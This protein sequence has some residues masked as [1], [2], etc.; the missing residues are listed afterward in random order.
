MPLPARD[1]DP[2]E[3]GVPCQILKALGHHLIIA[4]PEGKPVSA[5]PIMVT[6]KGLGPLRA[7]LRA[8]AQGRAAYHALT[9][10]AE[11]QAPITY[12]AINPA[13][14]DALLLPGGHA[15]GMRPYL[16]SPLL[17]AVVVSFF[18]ADKPVAAICH[19]TL[20][21]ARSVAAN[22]KSVLHG[23]KTTGLTRAQEL[24]AWGMTRAW[25]KDYY[26]TYPTPLETEI[27]TLLASPAD[28]IPGPAAI[29]RDRPD[30]LERGFTVLDGKY[31]SARW[32]GD[33]HRFANEFAALLQQEV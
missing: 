16:E 7:V 27:R 4:T 29:K 8:N 17:Q 31:L 1:F 12:A 26:R 24:L 20:L 19:G 5:D 22:G 33:A 23:R 13:E 28:F 21:A 25:M 32:P 11:F 10:S 9:R 30:R 14:Y 3:T 18:A 2:T 6:G 15:K